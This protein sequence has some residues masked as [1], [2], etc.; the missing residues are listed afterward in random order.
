MHTN[1]RLYLLNGTRYDW[2]VMAVRSEGHH[3]IV[4]PASVEAGSVGHVVLGNSAGLL[5]LEVRLPDPRYSFSI[6][7]DLRGSPSLA[8]DLSQLGKRHSEA[9]VTDPLDLGPTR[10]GGDFF[11]ALAGEF[12]NF[13]THDMWSTWM[14]DNPDLLMDRNLRQICMIGSHDAGMSTQAVPF[15]KPKDLLALLFL[16]TGATA[17]VVYGASMTQSRDIGNQLALGARWFDLRPFLYDGEYITGHFAFP[18]FLKKIKLF[19]LN[20]LGIGWPGQ[21]IDSI[22]DQV[23]AYLDTRAELVVLNFAHAVSMDT[24]GFDWN[25]LI[26]KLE[27][28]RHRYIVSEKPGDLTKTP[29]S[30]FIGDGRGCVLIR[31]YRGD[32]FWSAGKDITETVWA[33]GIY[34]EDHLPISPEG[35]YSNTHELTVM[36]PDQFDKLKKNRTHPNDDVFMTSWTLTYGSPIDNAALARPKLYS[37]FLNH[38]T[39]KSFPNVIYLDDVNS[40]LEAVMALGINYNVDPDAA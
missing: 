3:R 15:G 14:R 18:G 40:K 26:K 22:V 17:S 20:K 36:V 21:S 24:G 13:S 10:H 38:C 5:E 29:L 4:P 37:E 8:V 23:N 1:G 32:N 34:T 30:A 19:N 39:P 2:Y 25:V 11:F 12:G 33:K 6:C 27:R 35:K 9:K 16:V 7:I 31:F 28:L